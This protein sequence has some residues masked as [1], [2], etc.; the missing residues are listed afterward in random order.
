MTRP[1]DA[2]TWPSSARG[3]ASFRRISPLVERVALVGFVPRE[4]YGARFPD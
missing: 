1:S 4:P 3:W 2:R